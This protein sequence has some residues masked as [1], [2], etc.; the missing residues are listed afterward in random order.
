MVQVS[1]CRGTWTNSE[2]L[3]LL[4]ATRLEQ[5]VTVHTNHNVAPRRALDGLPTVFPRRRFRLSSSCRS[6]KELRPPR[7]SIMAR[8]STALD[9]HPHPQPGVGYLGVNP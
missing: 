3:K 1:T 9:C 2:K 5:R 6:R 4:V 7:R 8:P